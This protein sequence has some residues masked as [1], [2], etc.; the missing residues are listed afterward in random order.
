MR[1]VLVAYHRG[2]GHIAG[3][4]A[5]RWMLEAFLVA[6]AEA[7]QHQWRIRLATDDDLVAALSGTRCRECTQD[8][9]VSS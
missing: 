2:C 7:G 8:G 3:V 5:E 4:S 9:E 1:Q 6:M